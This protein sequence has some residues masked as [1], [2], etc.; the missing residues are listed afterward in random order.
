MD[1][2]LDHGYNLID[3]DGTAD[4]LGLWGPEKLKQRSM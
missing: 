2:I 1:H 4:A 3:L